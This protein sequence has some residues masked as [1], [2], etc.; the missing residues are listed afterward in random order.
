MR[1]ADY[2]RQN[3]YDPPVHPRR[4]GIYILVRREKLDEALAIIKRIGV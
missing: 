2:D 4:N 1:I 3:G